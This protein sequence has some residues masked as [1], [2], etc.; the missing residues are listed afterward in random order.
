MKFLKNRTVLGILCI[1]LS[2]T[3]CFFI[4]PL[5]NKAISQKTGIVRVQKVIKAGD[6]ITRE[7]VQVV[8]VGGYNLPEDVIRDLETVV[9]SYA[10]S[11]LAPGDYILLPKVSAQ[12]PGADTYLY[13]LDGSKQA[14]SVTVR[15]FAA[16]LSGK[17]KGGD[18][19]SIIAPDYRKMGETVIPQ[20]LQYIQVIAVTAN[21]GADANT[22]TDE[23]E[24]E[25]SLPATLTLLAS[26]IQC[27]V[28]AEL[29]TEGNLHAALVYRGQPETA[30][31]F[32]KAQEQVLDILYPKESNEGGDGG[33][34][35]GTGEGQSEEQS[36]VKEEMT[37]TGEEGNA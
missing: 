4:T 30:G 18:I 22:G 26:P 12:P 11:D 33:Q 24:K 29:E 20:E 16:G 19:V 17:I 15:S 31:Q 8:E 14:I 23:K 25:K 9:G 10:V 36:P 35:W 21:S 2:L 1:A 37:G 27:K 7:K 5:F 6:E 32:I 13:Q 34:V 3:I 28:L